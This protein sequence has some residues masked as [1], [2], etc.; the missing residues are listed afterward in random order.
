MCIYMYG[1]LGA[2]A[3]YACKC[4]HYM[5]KVHVRIVTMGEDDEKRE[6]MLGMKTHWCCY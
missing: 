1:V 3:T 4:G 2:Q 6:G 5:G